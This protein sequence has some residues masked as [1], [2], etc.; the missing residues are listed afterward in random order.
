MNKNVIDSINRIEKERQQLAEKYLSQ[1]GETWPNTDRLVLHLGPDAYSY[2][3]V[4]ICGKLTHIAGYDW[5]MILALEELGRIACYQSGKRYGHLKYKSV[6]YEFVWR[7]RH[8]IRENYNHGHNIP[9][10]GFRS[11]S[12]VKLFIQTIEAA[13]E[14]SMRSALE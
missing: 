10:S 2:E 5:Y 4:I 3:L 13:E 14:L 9:S 8:A 11:L 6:D 1:T 12:Q 7:Y